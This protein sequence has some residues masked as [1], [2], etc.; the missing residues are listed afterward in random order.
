MCWLCGEQLN[1]VRPYDHYKDGHKGGGTNNGE[2]RCVVYGDPDWAKKSEKSAQ[3]EAEKALE[4][5]LQQNPELREVMDSR[6]DILKRTLSH[7]LNNEPDNQKKR[8]SKNK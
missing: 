5:Y 3:E 6:R 1:K 2:S 4:E 7:H 8:R